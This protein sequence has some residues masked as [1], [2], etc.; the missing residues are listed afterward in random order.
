VRVE[1]TKRADYAIRAVLA[2]ARTPGGERR[3]VRWLAVEQRVPVRFL[4]HVMG[5]LVRAGLV[6]ATVGRAGGY[7]LARPAAKIPLLDVI[8]A[9]EGDSQRRV[10]VLRGGP[11]AVEGVCDVHEVFASAEADVVRRLG[12]TTVE[13]SIRGR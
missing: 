9:V 8:E 10:C 1:L 13:E 4:H 11:C 2:L 12:A 7:R 5:D 6:E 3:S